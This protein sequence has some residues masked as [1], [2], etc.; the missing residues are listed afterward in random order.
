ML[1]NQIR[2]EPWKGS[3]M[4]LTNCLNDSGRG[5]ATERRMM[6]LSEFLLGLISAKNSISLMS[7]RFMQKGKGPQ[8]VWHTAALNDNLIVFYDLYIVLVEDGDAVI[9]TELSKRDESASFQIVENKSCLG[10]RR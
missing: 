1:G 5:W 10:C 3:K 8:T 4:S 7:R 2:S 9:V 6:I